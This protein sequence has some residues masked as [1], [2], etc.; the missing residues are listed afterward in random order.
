MNVHERDRAGRTPLHYA[1]TRTPH[2][3]PYIAAQNDPAL[4]AEVARKSYEFK[5]ANT[6]T[7]LGQGA[8]V[9]AVDDEGYAPLHIAAASDSVDIVQLLLDNGAE[10]NVQ[11]N[12]GE[13]P[14]YSAVRNT[15]PAAAAIM[16]LLRER[17]AD[18]TIANEKGQTPLRFVSRFGKPE[19]REIFADLL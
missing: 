10:I 15:T 18:P 8:D 17:G 13:T 11:S 3:L 4:A 7:L 14:L 16:R 12:T 2:D 5:V 6:T 19:E 1:V 9:N